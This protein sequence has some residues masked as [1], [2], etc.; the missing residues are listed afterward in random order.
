MSLKHEAPCASDGKIFFNV[1]SDFLNGERAKLH[2]GAVTETVFLPRR[3]NHTYCREKLNNLTRKFSEL[4]FR[5]SFRARLSVDLSLTDEKL[6]AANDARS[7][8]LHPNMRCLG[9]C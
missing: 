4:E 2:F 9:L 3:I 8:V 5:L 6:I 7:S 1:V